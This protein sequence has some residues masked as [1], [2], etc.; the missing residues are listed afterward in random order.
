MTDTD[1]PTDPSLLP[2]KVDPEPAKP[3][4]KARKRIR[5]RPTSKKR[6]PTRATSKSKI[7]PTPRIAFARQMD[8]L[9][10]YGNVGGHEGRPVSHVDVA[11]LVKI[12][13]STASLANPFFADVGLL[14]RSDG[15]YT[16]SREVLG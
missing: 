7:L 12:A 1:L 10:A 14:M 15:G 9:R 6:Q 2:A 11:P 4:A 13:A 16:P 3:P 5:R 8:L